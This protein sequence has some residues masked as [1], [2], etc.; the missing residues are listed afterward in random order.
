MGGPSFYH[1]P[2]FPYIITGPEKLHHPPSLL[3]H[4]DVIVYI[5]LHPP[6]LALWHDPYSYN[7]PLSPEKRQPFPPGISRQQLGQRIRMGPPVGGDFHTGKVIGIVI[8]F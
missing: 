6:S 2:P 4:P 5:Y 1:T 7:P 3:I 8:Q